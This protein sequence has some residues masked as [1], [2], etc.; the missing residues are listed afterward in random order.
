MT[1]RKSNPCDIHE[2]V[3]QKYN[4]T[5]KSKQKPIDTIHTHTLTPVDS[6]T[7]TYHE[8]GR[9]KQAELTGRFAQEL[10]IPVALQIVEDNP[11]GRLSEST[12]KGILI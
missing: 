7:R 5:I 1:P 11:S 10:T 3:L 9:A 4:V 8:R 6:K 2:H 12:N